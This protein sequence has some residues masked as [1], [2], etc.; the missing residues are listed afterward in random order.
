M[1]NYDLPYPIGPLTNK[2][3]GCLNLRS[4]HMQGRTVKP[5]STRELKPIYT[6]KNGE[7]VMHSAPLEER[8]SVPLVL[9]FCHNNYRSRYLTLAFDFTFRVY[10]DDGFFQ[11]QN[12]LPDYHEIDQF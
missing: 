12:D 9:G 6:R 2:V 11:S 5:S 8:N 7:M 3:N 4:S 10:M 1:Q